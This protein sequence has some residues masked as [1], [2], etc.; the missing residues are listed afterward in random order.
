[1]SGQP[2]CHLII[3]LVAFSQRLSSF[4]WSRLQYRDA[5]LWAEKSRQSDR[6]TCPGTG[7]Q[8]VFTLG[9][10]TAFHL[11]SSLH[12]LIN[13]SL[14]HNFQV[15]GRLMVDDNIRGFRSAHNIRSLVLAKCLPSM[16]TESL[17]HSSS[18]VDAAF[19]G[20]KFKLQ[21]KCTWAG[22]K[23]NTCKISIYL[24]KPLSMVTLFFFF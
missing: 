3:I 9:P 12:T 6:K 23:L 16:V 14:W 11:Q 5:E 21:K 17:L 10:V 13:L 22:L 8:N 20:S 2:T 7:F 18:K 4:Q 19:A 15:G 24:T 1:M